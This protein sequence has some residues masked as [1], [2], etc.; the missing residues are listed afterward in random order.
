MDD[1][2]SESESIYRKKL[3]ELCDTIAR[4]FSYLL[5]EEDDD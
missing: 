4:E 2:S 5:E 1:D 3:I